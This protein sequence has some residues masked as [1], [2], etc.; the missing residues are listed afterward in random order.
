LRHDDDKAENR[1]NDNELSEIPVVG[2]MAP[3]AKRKR[4]LEKH[5]QSFS[6]GD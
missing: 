1:N 4:T 6:V 3:P 2:E 5:D